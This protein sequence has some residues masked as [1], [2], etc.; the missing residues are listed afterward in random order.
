MTQP[1]Y[2]IPVINKLATALENKEEGIGITYLER[3]QSILAGL[4]HLAERFLL[5]L[6]QVLHRF[7]NF[8]GR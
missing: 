7:E 5:A 6:S 2:R 8:D 3:F 4:E 1:G